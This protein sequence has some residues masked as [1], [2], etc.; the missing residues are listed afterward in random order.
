MVN[1]VSAI[2]MDKM[3]R[4][5]FVKMHYVREAYDAEMMTPYFVRSADNRSGGFNKA[6]GTNLH[7]TLFQKILFNGKCR[8]VGRSE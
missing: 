8:S 2:N 1:S 6:L 7:S 3:K 4:S 5:L